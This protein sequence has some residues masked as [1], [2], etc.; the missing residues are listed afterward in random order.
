ME[1]KKEKKPG[2]RVKLVLKIVLFAALAAVLAVGA[3]FAYVMFIDPMS[4]FGGNPT[5][6]PTEAPTEAPTPTL[7]PTPT[8]TQTPTQSAAPTASPT[9]EPTPTPT[10]APTYSPK[11]LTDLSF[12]KNRVN[13]LMLGWDQSPERGEEGSDV[14]RDEDNNYRSDVI[15]LLTVNFESGRADLI[16]VPRDTFAT[17]YT[18]KGEKYS[19][20][21]HWKIN[22]AFAKG[23]SAEGKGFAYAMQTVS[24][25]LGGIPIDYYAGV[26][27]TGLKAVV[28]AMGGV[29]Y[30]VD[31]RI[32][33]N[34]R[35]LEPGYQHLDG[36]QVLDYCRARKGIS[37]DVGRN[38]RQQRMLF[39]VF[40]QLKSRGQLANILNIY[41][42]VK[43]YVK[44]NLTAEQIAALGVFGMQL[45]EDTLN[46]HTLSGTYIDNTSYNNASYYVLYNDK[47][48]SLIK[49]IFGITIEPDPRADAAHVEGEKQAA[50]ARQYLSGAQY[51][52]ELAD[53]NMYL[54]PS[55]VWA[56]DIEF[57]IERVQAAIEPLPA[58]IERPAG[59][60]TDVP[61]DGDA[62]EAAVDALHEAMLPL[63]DCL[64]LTRETADASLLPE[65]FYKA[66]PKK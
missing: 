11:E 4:A 5:P 51:L 19:E 18:D 50:I 48:V 56:T 12:M 22:A 53:R 35:V 17:L 40:N 37:T 30:E 62:I 36:Q 13:I 47:L 6:A 54:T 33:L 55:L 23:G 65:A 43:G 38:D 59:V 60:S 15:M 2:S 52:L 21:A 8:P 61:L 20:T 49:Q 1:N 42:S 32:E 64:E 3:R 41:N 27:M 28:D 39:A 66:L 44:T 45:N 57:C 29:D 25:L 58:L 7:A 9:P 63:A 14:Y 10:P 16:S 46:R 24:K 34:G 26:D 31:V